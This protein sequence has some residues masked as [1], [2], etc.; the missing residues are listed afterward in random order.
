[1]DR[2]VEIVYDAQGKSI[3]VIND[4]KFKGK[5]SVD[6]DEVKEYL[7]KYVGDFYTVAD[8]NDIIY[9]GKDLPDEYTGSKYT[10]SL[11]G[12]NVKAKVNAVQGIP[13]LIKIAGEKKVRNNVKEKHRLKAKYGWYKYKTR[14]ALP[15]YDKCGKIERFNVFGAFMIVRHAND[16]KLYLYDII[17]I[18]KEMSTPFQS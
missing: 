5:R 6:W 15:V 12:T 16:G 9:I 10:Y 18:K 7:E 2:K 3:V 1:M 11:R 14:F 8:T 17:D 4:I 13:E